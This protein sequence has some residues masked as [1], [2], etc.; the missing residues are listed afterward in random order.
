MR[1]ADF[2]LAV[3]GVTGNVVS[4]DPGPGTVDV[5]STISIVISE[6]PL[7]EPEP[8]PTQDP[9]ANPN[10]PTDVPTGPGDNNGNP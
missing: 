3:S 5:G 8:E 10:Q 6:G 7:P 1:M 9:T 4:M 2:A